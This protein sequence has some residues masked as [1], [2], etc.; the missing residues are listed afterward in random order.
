M[1]GMTQNLALNNQNC[2]GDRSL[3]RNFSKHVLQPK[4]RLVTSSMPFYFIALSLKR[5]W[6]QRKKI[7]VTLQRFFDD[8]LSKYLIFGRFSCMY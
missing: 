6:V 8:P 4:E 2:T 1:F 5:D 7:K 3:K